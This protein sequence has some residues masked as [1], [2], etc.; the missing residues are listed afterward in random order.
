MIAQ[1]FAGPVYNHLNWGGYL[2]W[3]WP[4][5]PVAID[6]R[7]NLHGE[8]LLQRNST[9]RGTPAPVGRTTPN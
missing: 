4:H 7:T 1:G 5:L 8:E 9:I 2:I 6:G 3:R